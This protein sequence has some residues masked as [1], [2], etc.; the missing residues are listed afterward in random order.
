M[1]PRMRTIAETYKYLQES[2]P[3]TAMNPYAI[4]RL[5]LTNT[6]PFVKS[7][8]KYLI[9]LDLLEKYLSSPPP[10]TNGDIADK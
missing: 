6:I 9:N 2:D 3:E 10:D 5:I 1:L 7:G 8:N 4:R